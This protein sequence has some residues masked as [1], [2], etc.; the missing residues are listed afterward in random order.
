MRKVTLVWAAGRW[1]NRETREVGGVTAGAIHVNTWQRRRHYRG[2]TLKNQL[3]FVLGLKKRAGSLKSVWHTK[4]DIFEYFP[5]RYL[6]LFH[7][8]ACLCSLILCTKPIF[9]KLHTVDK[10]W[11]ANKQTER[12][13]KGWREAGRSM[14]EKPD[15]DRQTDNVRYAGHG[16]ANRHVRKVGHR[17]AGRHV[18]KSGD[19]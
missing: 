7:M 16:Q 9:E 14:R 19:R 5:V 12:R 6:P 15:T 3:A 10:N 18:R 13:V 11:L 4:S 1:R 17:Q 8:F 2:V